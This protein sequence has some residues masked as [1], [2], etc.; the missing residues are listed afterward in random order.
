MIRPRRVKWLDQS[1]N[2]CWWE[3]SL[4]P[5]RPGFL[6]RCLSNFSLSAGKCFLSSG[7]LRLLPV[8]PSMLQRQSWIVTMEDI[9]FP[10]SKI[11]TLWPLIEKNCCHTQFI[12]E[13]GI[14][15]MAWRKWIWQGSL[16]MQVQSLASLS[17]L[18][19]QCWLELRCRSQTQ[20]GSGIAVAVV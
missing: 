4:E 12:N 16:R 13:W 9:P 8:V 15:I 17:G 14:P 2:I 18:R 1:P 10:R 20:L 7:L 19:I 5:K 11:F 6:S 3:S